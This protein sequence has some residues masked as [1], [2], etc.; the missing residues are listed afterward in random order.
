MHEDLKQDFEMAQ[1]RH[2]LFK[3]KLRSALY[4][5]GTDEAPI[6][7]AQVCALG[8]WIRERALITYAHLP[9]SRELDKVHQQIHQ[10]A[11]RLLD[12]HQQGKVEQAIAGL[13]S[14]QG[15]VD[16]ITRLLRTME[17]KLRAE[18]PGLGR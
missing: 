4:G 11:N 16:E 9:E 10:E 7:D 3:S 5:S 17:Q 18:S 12:L 15:Y 2:L 1:V 6:R 14:V 13:T 8:V